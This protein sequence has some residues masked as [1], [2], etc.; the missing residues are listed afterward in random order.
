MAC[1]TCCWYSFEYHPF[2]WCLDNPEDWIPNLQNPSV[3]ITL[4]GFLVATEVV[5]GTLKKKMKDC[6]SNVFL[7]PR[8]V[9]QNFVPSPVV[10]NQPVQD[11]QS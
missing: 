10:L 4:G 9:Y 3:A 5:D 6:D 8:H 11:L 1:I 2:K 7:D